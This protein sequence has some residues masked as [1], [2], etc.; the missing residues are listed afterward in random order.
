M[1]ELTPKQAML[2]FGELIE[3]Y[4]GDHKY[5]GD[6]AEIY[7]YRLAIATPT[8]S[9]AL[10]AAAAHATQSGMYLNALQDFGNE[11]A[12]NLGGICKL[13]SEAYDAEVS[14]NGKNVSDGVDSFTHRVIVTVKKRKL[15]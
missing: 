3:C 1:L 2:V 11:A 5:G 12:A 14:V 15:A 8:V 9:T 13:F 4:Y 10:S 7:A 6:S